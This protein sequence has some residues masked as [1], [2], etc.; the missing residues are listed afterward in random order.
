[1]STTPHILAI[2]LGTSGPK[3]AL[4]A[5]DGRLVA[6]SVRPVRTNEIP[7]GGAEQDPDEIW[8]AVLAAAR[9]TL[10]AADLPPDAIRGVICD[11]HYFSLV[12]VD[13]TGRA[14]WPCI[15]W[16]D[17]RGAPHVQE[18]YQRAP[19]TLRRWLEVHGLPS[20]P[21]GN[22]SLAHL[23]WIREACPEVYERTHAFV[24]PMDYV[25]ARLTGRICANARTI[26]PLVLTDNRDLANVGYDD[27]LLRL[28]GVDR[29]KLPPLIAPDERVGKL[30]P[31]V[32][33]ALGL[34]PSTEV[35]TGLNDTQAVAVAAG[36]FLPGQGGINVGTTTQLLAHVD[37][38][39]ADLERSV[40]AM[41]S[42]L[43]GRYM[44]LGENGLG[45]K[46]LEHFVQNVV[47][48]KDGFADHSTEDAY[49]QLE[50]V[51]A[52]EPAGSGGLLFLPWYG[53]AQAPVSDP[54]MRGAFLNLSLDA[55][56]TRMM[57]AIVEGIAFNMRWLLPATE[58]VH[59]HA[60]EELRFSGGGA[61]SDTWSQVMADVMARP[62]LQVDEP[63]YLNAKGAAFVAFVQAGL[64]DLDRIDRFCPTRRRYE[65]D[66]A[67]SDLYARL[68]E[69][70]LKAFEQNRSI[71]QALNAEVSP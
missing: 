6:R 5:A 68:F 8:N 71:C 45:G 67:R 59:G 28:T 10:R 14:T 2:D 69:Q 24:E 36:T 51:I 35:F 56:R 48:S 43:P 16:M 46:L 62:V 38:M 60:F 9:E 32:A 27:E 26:F 41:P 29:E 37:G 31:E 33:E 50:Q 65:P 22:D 42:G 19:E 15:L 25:N 30:L 23:L 54:H 53:G 70:F 17:Q 58:E 21:T 18:I 49:A 57:R 66:A 1:M 39:H 44:L 55:T 12:P 11:S 40:L 4:V 3:V 63:R 13:A 52:A 7:G 64:T 34:S 20:L 47:Y 61:I